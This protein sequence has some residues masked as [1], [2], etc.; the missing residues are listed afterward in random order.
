MVLGLN[1]GEIFFEKKISEV[2]GN[3][4]KYN[5]SVFNI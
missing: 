5:L 4:D 1:K 3:M 2:L